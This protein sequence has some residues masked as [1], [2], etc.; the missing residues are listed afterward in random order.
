MDTFDAIANYKENSQ[1]TTLQNAEL[2]IDLQ[3]LERTSCPVVFFLAESI[4][5]VTFIF[6]QAHRDRKF[7]NFLSSSKFKTFVFS[8]EIYTLVCLP[9]SGASPVRNLEAIKLIESCG[10]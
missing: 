7:Q 9:I 10:F 5:D 2:L 6:G 3:Q 1:R 4:E 8:F